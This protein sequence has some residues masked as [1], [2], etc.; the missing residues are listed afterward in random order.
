MASAPEYKQQT[1][2]QTTLQ[3]HTHG[4]THIPHNTHSLPG[5]STN[6]TTGNVA[7][8]AFVAAGY[9]APACF[10][11]ATCAVPGPVIPCEVNFY[12]PTVRALT[13]APNCTA[14]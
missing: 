6:G 8:T 10:G 5:L 2:T 9:Q 1:G 11:L 4:L 12:F 7:C 13:A 14:W 3:S